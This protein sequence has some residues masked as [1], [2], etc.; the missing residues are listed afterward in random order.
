MVLE[1]P[2]GKVVPSDVRLSTRPLGT[3]YAHWSAGGWN[4][5]V[6]HAYQEEYNDMRAELLQMLHEII[7]SDEERDRPT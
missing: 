2:F 4:I 7:P 6:S 3:V 5:K 1:G